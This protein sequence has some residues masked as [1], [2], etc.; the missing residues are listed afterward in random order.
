M[1]TKR[2]T[3]RLNNIAKWSEIGKRIKSSNNKKKT[4]KQISHDPKMLRKTKE[5]SQDPNKKK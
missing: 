2:M 4:R 3:K 5:L 1:M